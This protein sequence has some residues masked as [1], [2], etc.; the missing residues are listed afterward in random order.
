MTGT[1]IT[2][3]TAE[4][5]RLLQDGGWEDFDQGVPCW[6]RWVGEDTN[7]LPANAQEIFLSY[8]EYWMVNAGSSQCPDT[9]LA[10][11]FSLKDALEQADRW[12]GERPVSKFD[13]EATSQ[14]EMFADNA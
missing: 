6:V 9:P 3:I 1:K 11:C 2:G 13:G 5:S 14:A 7:D 8:G 10:K 4:E 12:K